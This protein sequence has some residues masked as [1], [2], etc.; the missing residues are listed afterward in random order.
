ML[1]IYLKLS[2]ARMAENEHLA[3]DIHLKMEAVAN[4]DLSFHSSSLGS[5]RMRAGAMVSLLER[6]KVSL[7]SSL[8]LG[9][10]EWSS[11]DNWCGAHKS[12]AWGE[13]LRLVCVCICRE[14]NLWPEC[15]VRTLCHVSILLLLRKGKVSVFTS[16]HVLVFGETQDSRNF[17]LILL[18]AILGLWPP[19]I[20]LVSHFTL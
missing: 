16:S 20:F 6:R 2:V 14:M 13:S 18:L 7:Q 5:S 9:R 11:E 15:P 17:S 19:P 3:A 8:R 12:C 10:R 1:L 4:T